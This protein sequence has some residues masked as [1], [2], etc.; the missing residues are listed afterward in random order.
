MS[1]VEWA[2][3]VALLLVGVVGLYAGLA[4]LM[5]KYTWQ[6][7]TSPMGQRGKVLIVL[8]YLLGGAVTLAVAILWLLSRSR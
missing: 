7:E 5:G 4:T 2:T 6:E 3:L 8:L 1:F